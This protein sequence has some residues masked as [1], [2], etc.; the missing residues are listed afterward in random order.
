MFMFVGFRVQGSV[1]VAPRDQRVGEVLGLIG[2]LDDVEQPPGA[3]DWSVAEMMA[4]DTRSYL[5]DD[6]LVKV[7]RAAMACSLETR[8]PL[9]D[10]RVVAL[11]WRLPAH[12]KL[13]DGEGKWVLKQVLDRYVPRTLMARPKMGFDVPLDSWLRGPLRAWAENLL[14]AERLQREGYF[15]VEQVRR[16]WAEHLSGRSNWQGQLWCVLMFQAWLEKNGS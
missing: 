6:I 10:H 14:S 8:V 3:A 16:K 15:D 1:G 4:M 13:R 9:L 7:D 2:I 12:L 5:P 11:A